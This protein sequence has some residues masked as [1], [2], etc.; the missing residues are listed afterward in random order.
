MKVCKGAGRSMKGNKVLISVNLS[1]SGSTGKIM[2]QV[3]ALAR[4]IGYKTRQ[5]YPGRKGETPPRDGDIVIC[6]EFWN[7]I[8][9]RICRY[10]GFNGCSAV[11]PTLRLLK[12]LDKIRPTVIQLHN[13][14]HSYLNLP[15]LFRYIK[16]NGI[17]VVWT[18]HD[19]W[20]F[21]GHCPHFLYIG[22]DKWRTQCHSCP[23]YKQYPES[24]IDD[25]KRMYRL[26]KKWFCGV[27]NM[28][29][30]TPSKWLAGLVE[31][32]FLKEY[33]VQVIN[34]GIDLSVFQ[35]V[36]SDI[37]S[38][39]NIPPDAKLLL[40]VAYGWGSH[41]KGAD[42]IISL[43]QKLPEDYRIIMVGAIDREL[44]ENV[45]LIPRT[46]DQQEL[47]QLYTAADLFVMPSR[48]E[49]YPTVV[50]ESLACGTPVVMYDAGG[51]AE[52]ITEKTGVAVP[53]DDFE[54]LYREVVRVCETR[55][56]SEENCLNRAKTFDMHIK[57]EEYLLLY[58]QICDC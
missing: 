50:M 46:N 39:Y 4:E 9:Q 49:N 55:P 28:T 43:A 52:I 48:E 12:E 40:T 47:A 37:R 10:T 30:V 6:S 26:K 14:H 32:S 8:Y 25:S 58:K 29:I 13:L 19:C 51:G 44:P 31:Q 15:L 35:P 33:P 41:K 1:N 2:M 24:A 5:V 45:L 57:Y 23:L 7:K 42:V 18:L 11:I 27:E 20:V 16:K 36:Q 17:P 53:C 54:A 22:C 38:K 56:Y 21:T 34:N 3:A